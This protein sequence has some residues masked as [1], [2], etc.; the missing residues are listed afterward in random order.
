MEES[1]DTRV[2]RLAE[3][4]SKARDKEAVINILIDELAIIPRSVAIAGAATCNIDLLERDPALTGDA[5]AELP[6]ASRAHL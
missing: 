1:C 5:V 6:F 2:T 4:E 3:D